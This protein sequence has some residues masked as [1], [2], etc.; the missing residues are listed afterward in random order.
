MVVGMAVGMAQAPSGFF[1]DSP[2][3]SRQPEDVTVRAGDPFT[4]SFVIDGK[5]VTRYIWYK[6]SR[7]GT[8]RTFENVGSSLTLPPASQADAGGY[9]CYFEWD[10]GQFS[11]TRTSLVTVVGRTGLRIVEQPSRFAG[12]VGQT[13]TLTVK[14]ESAEPLRYQWEKDSKPI[15][16]ATGATLVIPNAKVSDTGTYRVTVFDTYERIDSTPVYVSVVSGLHFVESPKSVEAELGSDVTFS[17]LAGGNSGPISYQWNSSVGFP[18]GTV[19]NAATLLLRAVDGTRAGYYFVVVQDASG[20]IVSDSASLAIRPVIHYAAPESAVSLAAGYQLLAEDTAHYYGG[21]FEGAN[22][23][24][25]DAQ[26]DVYFVES[27]SCRIRRLTP[28][29]EVTILA[30]AAGCG[31]QDGPVAKSQFRDPLGVVV[32]S[33]GD[34]Y[35]ADA[36][37]HRIRR[38]STNG[39]VT[40]LAGAGVAGFADGIGTAAK[41]NYPN[42]LAMGADGSLYVSEFV[43]QRIRR[44]TPDGTVTTVLGN[45]TASGGEGP[46]ETVGVNRPGGVAVDRAG[47]LYFTEWGSHSVRCLST[48]GMVTTVAGNGIPGFVD[49]LGIHAHFHNPDGIAVDA[50]GTLFITDRENHAIRMI[51]PGGNVE[52]LAGDGTA[53]ES[54]GRQAAARFNLP[55]GLG[56]AP[57]GSLFVADTSNRRLVRLQRD[58]RA[59]WIVTH[60]LPVQLLERQNHLLRVVADGAPPLEYQWFR[61]EVAIPGATSAEFVV[62]SSQG[63]PTGRFHARVRNAFGESS[64]RRV[65]GETVFDVLPVITKAPTSVV[66]HA[67]GSATFAIEATGSG[68]LMYE[69]VVVPGFYE[70]YGRSGGST[71]PVLSLGNLPELRLG[72][73]TYY[74]AVRNVFGRVTLV[75]PVTLTIVPR[76]GFG[77]V[78]QPAEVQGYETGSLT[79]EVE[80]VGTA[81]LT[82]QWYDQT[83]AIPG[84]TQSSLVLSNLTVKMNGRALYVAVQD[85]EGRTEKSEVRYVSISP[86]LEPVM[87]L[88]PAAFTNVPIAGELRLVTEFW[89]FPPMRPQWFKDSLAIAGATNFTLDLPFFQSTDT[90]VYQ[91]EVSNR[92]GMQKSFEVRVSTDPD[93]LYSVPALSVTT[94]PARA[95]PPSPNEDLNAPR[96]IAVNESGEVAVADTGH[97]RIR[98]LTRGGELLNLA[99]DGT[100]GWADG[101]AA[102]SRFRRPA[103]LC[104]HPTD[105]ALWVADA[106][107]HCLRRIA[108]DGTVTTMAGSRHQGYLDGPAGD[109]QFDQPTDLVFDARGN[110]FITEFGSHAIRILT[111]DGVVRRWSGSVEMGFTDGPRDQARFARPAGMAIDPMGNLFLVELQGNRVR[112]ISMDGQ[113]STVL[114]TLRSGFVDGPEGIAR[115][116]QPLGIAVDPSGNLYLSDSGSHAIRRLDSRGQLTT[117]A[118]VRT[119]GAEDGYASHASFKQPSGL[120]LS[121]GGSLW[122]ADSGNHRIRRIAGVATPRIVARPEG[123]RLRLS[124]AEGRL[125]STTS[126]EGPW[127]DRDELVA[128]ATLETSESHRYFRVRVE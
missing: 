36:G 88:Y 62:S 31:Y 54:L 28:G 33:A 16:G 77:I 107:N 124:W 119:S 109:A 125:Q 61:D 75:P 2:Y 104:Y 6:L 101:P 73:F 22:G 65:G 4:L 50:D 79:F 52:T 84:A 26:G 34:V 99:G 8:E 76:T 115:L 82:Y 23:G 40:T 20:L 89:G 17:V 126:L 108:L 83:G 27:S 85:A 55:S 114:N 43:G 18:A 60:P 87:R 24:F 58:A 98:R 3:I 111:P 128:P 13:I 96:G 90:G 21:G 122:I 81:P 70:A 67:G 49:G 95:V 1:S 53:G 56:L 121:T 15:A 42:D 112:K 45:G 14:A 41:F 5:S 39:I 57:D 92:Y 94:V 44:I 69:W 117:A 12:G 106:G 63:T 9:V 86:L 66:A 72:T 25:V 29:R 103:G 37:N 110:L 32:S 38:I 47:N 116:R 48:N 120:V 10:R 46:R 100:E 102:G 113:V 68:P 93:V 74:A 64:T 71:N 19:T 35:V 123:S 59:P 91:L 11:N 7:F 80:A 97:H 78:R 105:G 51:H 118:G 127:L 30:G